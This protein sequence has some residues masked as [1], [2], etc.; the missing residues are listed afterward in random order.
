MNE[1]VREALIYVNPHGAVKEEVVDTKDKKGKAVAKGTP[2]DQVA[3][4]FSGHDSTKY[5]EIAN[6]ILKYIQMTTGNKDSIPGKSVDIV[7]L[8]NDDALLVNLFIQKLKFS[9]DEKDK[10]Q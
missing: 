8:I 10:S 6:Q 5:K 1:I 2:A 4:I 3:D 9:F 7:S